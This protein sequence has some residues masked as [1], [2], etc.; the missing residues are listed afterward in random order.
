M[1]PDLVMDM[2]LLM[3]W[4]QLA[5]TSNVPT[6]VLKHAISMLH[7]QVC[8]CVFCIALSFVS[9]LFYVFVCNEAS[10]ALFSEGDCLLVVS[11]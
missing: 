7:V 5:T 10:D 1:Q 11:F 9:F 3:A 2:Q 6:C 8:V 4:N